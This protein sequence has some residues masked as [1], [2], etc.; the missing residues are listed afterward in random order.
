MNS[1]AQQANPKVIG[2][3]DDNRDQLKRLSTF[4]MMTPLLP[5]DS[6]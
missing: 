2:N 5:N 1:M 3:R 6:W 4:V